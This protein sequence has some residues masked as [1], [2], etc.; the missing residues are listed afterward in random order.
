MAR[1]RTSFLICAG[2]AAI[3]MAALLGCTDRV[4]ARPQ[5]RVPFPILFLHGMGA[6]AETWI[7]AGVKSFL[8]KKGLRY[9][10]VIGVDK[11]GQLQIS[12]P[13]CPPEKADFFALQVADSFQ[14]LNLWERDLATIIEAVRSRTGAPR[15]ILVGHSAGGLAAR[16]YLVDHARYHHVAK[17][18]TI[19]TPHR[20][21]ELA[22]IAILEDL[23]GA[24]A[25]GS[26]AINT[27]SRALLEELKALES[28]AGLRYKAP[29]FRDLLPESLN[30]ALRRLNSAPHPTDVKYACILAAGSPAFDGWEDLERDLATISSGAA[31]DSRIF[32]KLRTLLMALVAS[33][34]QGESF[35]GDGAVLV[36]SQD[37][38]KVDFFRPHIE[39]VQGLDVEAGHEKVKENHQAIL[40]GIDSPLVFLGGRQ[41]LGSRPGSRQL[42]IDFQDYFAG[43]ARV[44]ARDPL[45]GKTLPVSGPVVLQKGEESFGRFVVGP[46]DP[47]RLSAIDFLVHSLVRGR[48]YGRRIILRSEGRRIALPNTGKT[49]PVTV[50]LLRVEAVPSQRPSGLPWEFDL[51]A[52]DIQVVLSVE[53]H[54]V[55]RSPILEDVDGSAAMQEAVRLDGNPWESE[56]ALEVWHAGLVRDLMGRITWNPEEFP[57]SSILARTPEG[58]G[59]RFAVS[60][61]G[62]ERVHWDAKVF[63]LGQENH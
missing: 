37:L 1:T 19:A 43:L 23:L 15:V 57:R 14:S 39:E 56:M 38:R 16:K 34:G 3:G 42:E 20:G 45:T 21:S 17:L 26:E 12:Q 31:L 60:G 13:S 47:T 32:E 52:P 4:R 6:T 35:R 51:S 10:G 63:V 48:V 44:T 50:T 18:L 30:P 58:V 62:Q 22:L 28:R 2:L 9:G 55:Y 40:D 8:E 25:S 27:T 29:I 49:Q 46:F 36:S 11:R 7:D 53:H 5:R 54:E 24:N 33:L 59:L 61:A 41:I